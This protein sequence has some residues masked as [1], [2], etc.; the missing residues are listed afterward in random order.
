VRIKLADAVR[1]GSAQKREDYCS[2]AFRP[3]SSSFADTSAVCINIDG[4]KSQI[5]NIIE[6]LSEIVAK[7]GLFS[8][9]EFRLGNCFLVSRDADSL[10]NI[11]CET[12]GEVK[13][14]FFVRKALCF[15]PDDDEMT[16]VFEIIEVM[17]NEVPLESRRRRRRTEQHDFTRTGRRGF[18][19]EF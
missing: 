8:L 11:Y 12:F 14:D 7:R 4:S 2:D 16:S 10:I 5:Q 15:V 13:S 3:I 9:A 1:S 19:Y 18:D 6:K 17:Q